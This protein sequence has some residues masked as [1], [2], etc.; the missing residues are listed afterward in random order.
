L[1]VDRVKV[2]LRAGAG[3]A[4]VV[5]FRRVRGKP[6]GKPEGGSGGPG[7][8]VILR[9]SSEVSTLLEYQ[10]RP[11]RSAGDG[12]HGEGGLR[13]GRRGRDLILDV[14]CGTIVR[15]ERGEVIADLVE[16]G[17]QVT[18]LRGGRGGRGNAA[19]VSPRN[20][21]PTFCEQGEYGETGT[22]ELELKLIADAALI[23]YPNAGKSTLISVVSAANPKIADY[24]FTTLE[25]HLGVVSVDGREL[26]LADVPGLIEGAAEGKGLGREFLRHVDRARALVILLDPTATQ[27][28]GVVEQHRVLLSEL[29]QYA[30]ELLDRPR[31][32]A[33][34]KIDA[35]EGTTGT[36]DLVRDLGSRVHVISAVR[37]DGV[38]ELM[39]A[40]A[41]LVEQAGRVAP[42]REGFILHRPVEESFS[43]NREDDVWVVSGRAA[44]RAVALAD[45]SVPAA[46]DFAA[47]RLAR[48]GVDEA[49]RKAGARPGDEVRIGDLT[50]EFWEED[51]NGET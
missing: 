29:E 28:V 39:H 20:R 49:L 7:G 43:I 10:R 40:V 32:V 23:G 47:G 34:N 17:Q 6:K 8:D 5:S 25:P 3:G 42:D 2:H 22:F 12:T 9:A 46:A 36:E 41:D 27:P 35:V 21:A 13:H 26:V 1:F 19:L 48:L 45:L 44:E 16:E 4:G 37:G 15:D 51:D 50:F 18:V 38:V 30:P 33:V 11:H 14:A 31:V 24:P